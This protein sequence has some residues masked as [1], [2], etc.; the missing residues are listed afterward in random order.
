M[1]AYIG[2]IRLLPYPFA[3]MNWF[4]CQG[5]TLPISGNAALFS[6]I[7]TMY[8]GNGTSTFN[9]PQLNSYSAL[10]AGSAPGLTP[11]VPGEVNGIGAVNLITSQ[12]PIHNH[13]LQAG[14]VA[15]GPTTSTNTPSSTV[16]LSKGINANTLAST[17]LYAPPPG[18]SSLGPATIGPPAGA[19]GAAHD[20]P[21]PYLA[22][23][24]CICYNGVFPPRG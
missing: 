24:Y 5:Q 6:I 13:L 3:P 1:D 4:A 9:L 11:Y 8:G 20:N 10:G 23:Q 18:N 19:S 2:E 12:L 22:L 17:S 7:G 14:S 15:A 21:Q 16:L